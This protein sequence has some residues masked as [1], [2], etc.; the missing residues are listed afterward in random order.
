MCATVPFSLRIQLITSYIKAIP[1][2]IDGL[3]ERNDDK[4]FKTMDESPVKR[5][6][7]Y[8]TAACVCS[9]LDRDG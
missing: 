4:K 6:R 8:A 2:S 5:P 3:L 9:G 7:K 1:G